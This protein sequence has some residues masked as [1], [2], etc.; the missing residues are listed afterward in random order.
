MQFVSESTV[1]THIKSIYAKL[2]I[3]SKQELIALIAD[4]G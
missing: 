2:G 4:R 1:K 3:H